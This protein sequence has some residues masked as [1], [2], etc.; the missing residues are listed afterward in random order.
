MIYGV[1]ASE[2]VC[3]LMC[4][5]TLYGNNFLYRAAG[6]PAV[7]GDSAFTDVTDA[8]AYYYNAI[9]WAAENGITAGIGGGLFTPDGI[10]NRAQIVTF[11]YRYFEGK[12]RSKLYN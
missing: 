1:I 2:I 10:C 6:S 5:L 7:T 4:G 12:L 3:L 9:L 11:I 8:N